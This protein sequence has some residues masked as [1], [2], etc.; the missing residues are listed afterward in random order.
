M[1]VKRRKLPF[2]VRAI[3]AVFILG[4]AARDASAQQA[5]RPS[6]GEEGPPVDVAGH[7][8]LA[9]HADLEPLRGVWRWGAV[10][11]GI[12]VGKD[13]SVYWAQYRTDTIERAGA[14]GGHAATI[15]KVDGP[16]GLA[17]DPVRGVLFYTGDR[18]YPRSIARLKPGT[19]PLGLVC[20]SRVNRPFAIA[21]GVT[22]RSIYWTESINGRVRSARSDGTELFT[23]FDDGIATVNEKADAVALSSAGIA[24]DEPRGFV[25]WSDLRT[26]TIVRARLDGSERTTILGRDQ[27][28]VFPTA[29]AV[30]GLGGELYW[31]DPGNES[32]GRAA[33]DGS[34]P[35]VVASAADGV[36]EP[37]GLAID[38]ERRL[39][40]WTD[41]A[42]N[43]IYRTPIEHK[44]IER[45]VDLDARPVPTAPANGDSCDGE[46]ARSAR[47]EFLRRWGKLIRTCVVDVTA[48]QAVIRSPSDLALPAGLCTRELQLAH[49][50]A[51]LRTGLAAQCD[52]RELAAAIDDTLE[53]GA[54]IV[55]ADLPRAASYLRKIRPFVARESDRTAHDDALAALDDLVARIERRER[56]RASAGEGAFPVSGQTTSYAATRKG[57]GFGAVP[58]DGAVR[59]GVPLAY[60]DNGDGTITS[61][62]AGL[63]WEKKCVG[64]GGLHDASARYRWRSS[65]EGETDVAG[66]LQAINAENGTGFGGHDDWR[67]PDIAELVSIA[68]YE[69]FNPALGNA[70]DRSSCTLGC[71]SLASAECSCSAMGPYWT[72]RGS[73]EAAD[74]VPVV[75]SNLGIVVGRAIDDDAFVRAVRGPRRDPAERFVDNGDGTITDRETHLM[76]EKKCA[77]RGNPH[78]V[79]RRSPWSFDATQET[80]WDWLDAVNG[81]GDRGFA[82][83]ADWRIPNVKELYSLVDASR[84]DPAIA[85]IFAGEGCV[86]VRS[87]RCSAAAKGLHWT[88]T[89]FADFPSLGLAVDFAAPG[90]LEREPPPGTI[91]VVGGIEPHEKT[92]RMVTRAVRGPLPAAP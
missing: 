22:G 19:K 87:R 40:Y 9:A 59:A 6:C 32:I 81:E 51:S 23:V 55:A 28:L 89:T 44:D 14:D 36:L 62:N 53:I 80:I 13:G 29:L 72:A 73:S 16:L 54:E 61:R 78:D 10:P 63:T 37:Y 71:D 35:R 20:G 49:D 4:L 25:F 15:A 83:H 34:L 3:A 5:A 85:R 31:A 77:C 74:V 70:F 7:L 33:L 57:K 38:A 48:T 60:A 75:L 92:L 46:G 50:V 39:L 64:C 76:W 8:A 30:D 26:A 68:D 27:G 84:N 2:S 41:I 17:I 82:G 79:D 66:W 67:L 1:V 21:V 56:A 69:R 43:A 11:V 52:G 58:D 91:R 42:R 12:A 90:K 86:D 88:S 24:I 45:F 47:D 18:H 65:R